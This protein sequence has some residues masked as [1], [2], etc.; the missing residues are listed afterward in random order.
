ML[1]ERLLLWDPPVGG[2][3][4]AGPNLILPVK[5]IE[6]GFGYIIL[7]TPYTPY[8]VYVNWDHKPY[9]GPGLGFSL[10]PKPG[11][12]VAAVDGTAP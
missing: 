3:G 6:Y 2:I 11:A 12:S 4:V 5:Y 10:N 9:N 8:S 7:R 1:F